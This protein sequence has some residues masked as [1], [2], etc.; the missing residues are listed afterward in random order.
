MHT[1]LILCQYDSYLFVS[2]HKQHSVSE[3]IF[4]Q[5]TT[6][7]FSGLSHTFSVITVH[8]K[9]QTW[10]SGREGEGRRGREREGGRGRE[11]EGE[12]EGERG[13]EK[14]G[15]REGGNGGRRE[16]E[17]EMHEAGQVGEDE[18]GGK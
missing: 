17:R 1:T 10:G 7:F 13:R 16:R 6:H 4:I 15:E 9:Y 2:K 11:G 14:E 18:E 5:H 8:N 3:F 12:R